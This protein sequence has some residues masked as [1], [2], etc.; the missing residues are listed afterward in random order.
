MAMGS[1]QLRHRK[2]CSARGKDNRTCRC[3]PTGYA[4]LNGQWAKIG[5]LQLG[6][7]KADLAPFE[8]ELAELR[9]I[10]EA[11]GSFKPKK[12]I[13]TDEY[14]DAWLDELYLAAEA[15][16]ISKL[17][18]NSYEGYWNNHLRPFFGAIP[19]AAI[20]PA[21]VR[22]YAAEKQSSGL[23][24]I[25]VN[26][27]LTPLSAMLT[28]AVGDGVISSNPVRQPRRARHGASLRKASYLEAR[29]ADPKF[30]EP[31]E[32][33]ALLAVTPPAYAEMVLA[34]LTTGFR[35]GELLGLCWENIKWADRRIEL[36]GQLQ[37]REYVGCKCDS[38]RE[39]VL[40]SRLAVELGRRRQAEG[41]V[42]LNP[43]GRPWTNEGPARV[44][45]SAAYEEAGI[46]RPGQMW[47]VLRHTFASVLAAGGIR[48]DVVERLMGH[49]GKGTTSIYTH[50]FR[51]AFDGVEEALDAVFGVNEPSMDLVVTT[52][53]SPAP[54]AA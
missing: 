40:Y 12:P 11:G 24:P 52:D 10:Q 34:A 31:D 29:R 48:R 13:R 44:S 6:W 9:S 15:G 42:F 28:D 19:L 51:D 1:V 4:V 26:H 7:R 49:S 27:T 54:S 22:R 35:R 3:A 14:G 45:L 43:Q 38:E 47:H 5:Y 50:L 16:R 39:V 53:H 25:S 30:L 20:D 33:R 46:R 17:T 37:N 18:Y 36:R 32:A 23:A 2:G 21:T 8:A 41:Y